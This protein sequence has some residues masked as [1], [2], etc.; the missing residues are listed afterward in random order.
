M[1]FW[2][3][4]TFNA[5]TIGKELSWAKESGFNSVRVPLQYA[6]WAED[7]E[8]F[9]KRFNVFL[10]LAGRRHLSV[11]PVL[12][13]DTSTSVSDPIPGKQPDPIPGVHNSQWTPSPGRSAV[14][15]RTKWSDL[16][17]YVRDVVGGHRTDSRI[18][19]WDLYNTPGSGGMGE[20]SLALL[21]SV[22]RWVRQERPHQPVSAAVWGD[23]ND[24]M[25]AR[26]MEL[27]D[28]VTFSDFDN[29]Q[30]FNA[31]MKACKASK[32]PIICAD[33]LKRQAG[34]TVRDILPMMSDNKVGWYMRGLVKGRA[35]LYMPDD[36][37]PG[38][39]E[40][41]VWQQDMLWPD[42][43]PYDRK[44]IDLIKGFNF[45]K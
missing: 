39:G 19:F 24:P 32:R 22:F 36:A 28:L 42:G 17:Q 11:T 10:D 12:F 8:G 9:K 37:K 31:R 34:N 7:P 41:A 18:L 2:Q 15:D 16:E 6:A 27:S 23:A 29:A 5:D 4:D 45:G 14:L 33:W 25:S 26:F 40:P 44:E 13:D 1:E 20:K 21:E 30:V 35:N 43:K 3:A 38:S